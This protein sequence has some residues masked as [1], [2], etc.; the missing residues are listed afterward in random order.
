MTSKDSSMA[1]S[2]GEGDAARAES[3]KRPT[4][5]D[6][7]MCANCPFASS[8]PGLALRN[9]LRP[10]RF[11]AIAQSVFAGDVFWCHKTTTEDGWDE[12]GED[13]RGVGRERECGGAVAFRRRA[14]EARAEREALVE[15]L[16]ATSSNLGRR[17][18]ARSA[19]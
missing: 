15:R 10:G 6:E 3:E 2:R 14:Q 17:R 7:V 16:R 9:T 13:Y 12:E 11:N 8:G 19:G 5:P 18:K 1:R 4:P